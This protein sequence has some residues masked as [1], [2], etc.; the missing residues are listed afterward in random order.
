VRDQHDSGIIISTANSSTTPLAA[1]ATFVGVG[2][3][4]TDYPEIT[5]NLFGT[6]DPAPG[7]LFFEFSPNGTDWD[8]S[9]P[10]TLTGPQQLVPQPLRVVLPYF[11]V[12]YVNGGTAQTAFRLTTTFHRTSAKH[13]TRFLNQTIGVGEPVENVRAVIAGQSPDGEFANS[14]SGGL[15]TSLSTSTPLGVSGVFTSAIVQAGE[16]LFLGMTVKSDVNSATGGVMVRWFKDSA[17]TILLRENSFTYSAAPNGAFFGFQ[18]QG[19]YVQVIYMNNSVAQ[20]LFQIFTTLETQFSGGAIQLISETVRDE[21]TAQLTK[22]IIIGKQENGTNNNV[23]LSNSASLKVAI[24]DRPSEVRSRTRVI[25]PIN[26]TSLTAAGV[27][28]YTVTVG[29]ILYIS[30]FLITQINDAAAIGEWRLQ[31]DVT[32]KSGFILPDKNVGSPS[33]ASPSLPEPMSF[34]TN[35]RGVEITGDIIIAGFLIGYEE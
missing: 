3:L 16:Y 5:I 30:A 28:F 15:I 8:V 27:T 21:D 17:G 31:D 14:R 1:A 35:V 32:V 20:T 22:S 24:T 25:I 29:K 9:V 34:V 19:E 13:L 4:V 12:R 2:E 11:R 10:I 6:P 7:T 26:R 23:G 33:G 18:K